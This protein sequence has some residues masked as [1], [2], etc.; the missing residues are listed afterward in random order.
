MQL[1][2]Q[3]AAKKGKGGIVGGDLEKGAAQGK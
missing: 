2:R 3:E 1:A